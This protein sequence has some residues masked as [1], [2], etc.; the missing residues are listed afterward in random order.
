MQLVW[1]RGERA[2]WGAFPQVGE[3][4]WQKWGNLGLWGPVR[5][6]DVKTTHKIVDIIIYLPRVM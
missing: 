6:G 2:K 1:L 4:I 5:L 3:Y